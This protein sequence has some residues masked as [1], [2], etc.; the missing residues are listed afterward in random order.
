MLAVSDRMRG[1]THGSA[2]AGT[3]NEPGLT[4]SGR[5]ATPP[6]VLLTLSTPTPPPVRR[7][8]PQR[9]RPPHRDHS[10]L[11]DLSVW[12]SLNPAIFCPCRS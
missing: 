10:S 6:L 3:N 8:R 7:L 11:S 1:R 4:P 9:A 5:P 12:L 2:L